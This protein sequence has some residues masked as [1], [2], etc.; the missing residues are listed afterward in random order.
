MN[1]ITKMIGRN[2]R[3]G[4]VPGGFTKEF[5]SARTTAPL[6]KRKPLTATNVRDAA[7]ACLA[8]RGVYLSFK[9]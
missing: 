8:K 2:I 4:I 3:A 7:N 9:E 5:G 6:R 1:P